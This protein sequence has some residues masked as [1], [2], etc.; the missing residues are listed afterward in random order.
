MTIDEYIMDQL[1]ESR[2]SRWDT[3][4]HVLEQ[5]ILESM[6]EWEYLDHCIKYHKEP[7]LV[8]QEGN[9]FKAIDEG[10]KDIAGSGRSLI[11]RMRALTRRNLV[12][13]KTLFSHVQDVGAGTSGKFRKDGAK[14]SASQIAHENL[15]K[16]LDPDKKL[17]ESKARV[18]VPYEGDIKQEEIELINS[19]ILIKEFN[20]DETFEVDLM[21]VNYVKNDKGKVRAI[22]DKGE[23]VQSLASLFVY[24]NAMIFFI[25]HED[26]MQELCDLITIGFEIVNGTQ[27]IENAEYVKRVNRLRNKAFNKANGVGAGGTR[28]SMKELT[29]FQSKLNELEEKLDFVQ[30]ANV[31]LD[32]VDPGVIDGL[33]KLVHITEHF[34]FGLSSLS[35][36]MQKVHLIDLKFMNSITDRNVL[37]KFVYDCIQNGI[38]PKY[39]AYNTWLIANESIRGSA[40][41]YKPVGGQTRCVFFPNDNKKEIL[42]I[43]TS[44]IGITSNKNEIRFSQFLKQSKEQEMIECSALVTNQYAQD[45]ILAMERVVDRVGKHPDLMT[46]QTMK[47]QYQQFTTRHPELRL[48]VSDFNDGNVMWS[49]DKDRWVCIDYGLGKRSKESDEMLEKKAKRAK[50]QYDRK[51]LQNTPS[52][53]EKPDE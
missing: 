15:R 53:E 14:K 43:A 29:A 3:E 42:K 23:G 52:K 2:E 47:S 6:K 44:G 49:S 19:A 27:T 39:I 51:S 25:K 46:L 17:D 18:K 22:S 41:R 48:V 11:T 45:A 1:Q 38:P 5:M 10:I 33:N 34:Q 8:F 4:Q 37:S 30:N 9:P 7:T 13:L 40:A 36:A 24:T 12:V 20:D 50:K 28:L 31:K 35:N 32:D 16:K 26:E 21:G